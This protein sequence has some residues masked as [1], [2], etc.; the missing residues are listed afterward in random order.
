VKVVLVS[1]YPRVDVPA[2]KRELA[3]GLL[4]EGFDLALLY[5]RSS[6]AD[7]AAAGLREFGFDSVRKAVRLRGDAE[8]GPPQQT[9]A[10]WAEERGVPIS[11][12]RRLGDGDCLAALRSMS[13]DLLVLAGSDLVPAAMLEIPRLGTINPHYGLLPGYRG[14]NVTEWSI[15]HGDPVGVTVHMVD[16][17][18]DTGAIVVQEEIAIEPGDT[19]ETLRAKHQEL[20]TRLLLEAAR[21]IASGTAQPIAQRPEDGRQYYRMHP[22]L[23]A[24]VE[25]KL[26]SVSA[27]SASPSAT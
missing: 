13:P 5:S 25:R 14:M 10:S 20:A 2:W 12:A 3:D 7:Q 24:A 1:R 21:Q 15:W 6:I 8:A 18:V 11:T 27:A 17:G 22:L 26:E 23:R 16:P 4:A 9:L 19:L